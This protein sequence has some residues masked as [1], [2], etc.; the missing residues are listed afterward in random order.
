MTAKKALADIAVAAAAAGFASLLALG[1]VG[2]APVGVESPHKQA[3]AALDD[4]EAAVGEL[5]SAS[6][7]TVHSPEPFK[8]AAKRAL[9]ALSGAEA[10][11][12]EPAGSSA[13]Q[14][15]AI[16]HLKWLDAHAGSAPWKAA[17][18][19]AEVNATV[20]TARLHEAI[21]ADGL[22][23]FQLSSTAALEAML[24]ALGHDSEVG[25]MGGLRGALAT[26]ELGV[27]EGAMMLS[28]CAAPKVTL[29]ET[30]AY[31]VTNGYLIFVAIADRQQN[32]R[33]PESIGARDIS[34]RNGTIVLYTAAT[35]KVGTIC[36]NEDQ[37]SGLGDGN[38]GSPPA[39]SLA[40]PLAPVG[41]ASAQQDK[42]DPPKLYSEAQAEQG[43]QVYAQNC[44][45]C[46]GDQLQG[47]SA[48]AIA[49]T[50][51]LKKAHLL[52]W[53]VA[54]MRNIIVTQM[55]RDNPGSLSPDQYAAVIAFLL[56]KDCYPAGQSK[57][58]TK[59]TDEIKNA[60]LH[61][62]KAADKTTDT[63]TCPVQQAS[64]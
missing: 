55:P 46:H 54:D 9:D 7:L 64:K 2:A 29:G 56:D 35:D 12:G 28:G 27:P 10:R 1:A 16:G 6:R 34:V 33:L 44:S 41:S 26:T 60:Q 40:V 49:G 19:G 20:A 61:P 39:I 21:D 62:V 63:G 43:K 32:T 36:P 4:I 30:P 31:G 14:Q 13:D 50:A 48:P 3:L 38:E 51:F 45:A 37:A 58:P 5:D 53:S 57:F 59:A 22:E 42:L 15:G 24:V 23:Q 47:K 25:A 11:N 8:A 52:G 18:Q 17:V